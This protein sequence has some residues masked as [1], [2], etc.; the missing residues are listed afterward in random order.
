MRALP[1]VVPALLCCAWTI[2]AGKDLNWDLLHYHLYLPYELLGGRM[3]QDYF[4]ASA[5]S[6]LNPLGFLPF[7][8]AVMSGLHSLVISLLFA[9][10]HSVN[11]AL[12]YLIAHRL[13]EHRAPRERV[14]L[15]ALAAALGAA[16]IVFWALAGTSFLDVLLTLPMLWAVLLL[17]HT[18]QRAGWAGVLFG[19]AASLKLSNAFFAL[20]GLALIR[21]RRALGGY[22]LG[23]AAAVLLLAAPWMLVLYREFGNPFF[24]HFNSIFKSPDFPPISLGAERFQPR[25]LVDALEFPLR[26][27]NPETMTYA[28]ISAPDLRFAALLLAVVALAAVALAR[29][30]SPLFAGADVSFAAFFFTAAV[31]W[32]GTS[33]NARYGLLV[34]LL[35]GPCLAR[36]VD[37]VTGAR[38]ARVILTVVLVAQVVAVALISPTRWFITERWSAEWFPF[39]VPERAQREPTL[40][41]VMESQSMMSV[42]PFLHPQSSFVNLR[43]QHSLAPSWKRIEA[44]IARHGSRVRALGRGLRLQADGLPRPEVVEVYDST[45]LRFGFRLDT[46]D[47]FAIGWQGDESG[48]LSR[49]AAALAPHLETRARVLSLASCALVRA[50]RDPADIAAEARMSKVFDRIERECPRLFREQ[51]SL[52][53]PL[54]AEWSRTYA[55][56]EAR[57]ETIGSRLALVPY[58]KL[59]YFDLGDIADW[60]RPGAA[61]Q[62]PSCREP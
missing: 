52:T 19:V 12:L 55:G 14:V 44:L 32:I 4:A 17:L 9:A 30:R 62:P 58:F 28:E 34:L 27:M 8:A 54:G 57:L 29:R 47:C 13:L 33:G 6:Y 2:C 61:P 37:A 21:G 38:P 1:F 39:V 35:V 51:T 46:G 7:Y 45:M 5:Q 48:W 20:A 25:S 59:I 3:G 15:A 36:L 60:E 11:I 16:T 56:L 49:V 31:A 23:G 50:E 10:V 40:Y 24:P 22:V 53:E 26:M 41:L 43:G 18:P 42:A